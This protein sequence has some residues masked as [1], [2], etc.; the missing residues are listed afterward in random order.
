[1]MWVYMLV[2]LLTMANN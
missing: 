1:M 2:N